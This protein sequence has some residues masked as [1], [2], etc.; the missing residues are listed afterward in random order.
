M[1]SEE[2]KREVQDKVSRL[3]TEKFA[4]DYQRAFAH[5]DNGPKDGRIDAAELTQLLKDAGIGNWFTRDAWVEG[6]I[7]ALDTDQDGAISA[8]EFN[9]VLKSSAHQL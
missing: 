6:I 8:T 9:A 7:D 1:A 3:V 4:G 2:Q 5:Y